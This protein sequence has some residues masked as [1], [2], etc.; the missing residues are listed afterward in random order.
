[1]L[2]RIPSPSIY[3][4]LLFEPLKPTAGLGAHVVGGLCWIH[5][6]TFHCT[7]GGGSGC[8]NVGTSS[9]GIGFV[10]NIGTKIGRTDFAGGAVVARVGIEVG[11]VLGPATIARPIIIL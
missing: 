1:M 7:N 6:I 8:R 9:N 5:I 11:V 2:D 10:G 4:G 3:A